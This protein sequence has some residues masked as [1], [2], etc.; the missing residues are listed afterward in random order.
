MLTRSFFKVV[1]LNLFVKFCAMCQIQ[2]TCTQFPS[3]QPL[4]GL[5]NVAL[6]EL[7][8]SDIKHK[9]LRRNVCP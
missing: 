8:R 1:F 9:L 4:L 5:L 3:V 2:N 7:W 6:I